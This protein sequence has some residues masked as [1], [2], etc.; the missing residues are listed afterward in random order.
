MEDSPA[1]EC[2]SRPPVSHLLET[3]LYVSDL[4]TSKAFYERIFGF[5]QVFENDR[6]CALEVPGSA[7]LLLFVHNGAM[8]PAGMP[9]VAIPAHGGQGSLHVC[10]AIPVAS[11]DAW[12]A[13][14][15]AEFISVES[16]VTWKYGGTSVYFRDPDGHS[17]EIATPG[18]WAN[19]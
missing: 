11:L 5:T 13:H 7:V 16:K 8:Q 10:F 18:L 9:G 12:I 15:A 3:S 14:L 1:A 17:V 19:Y 2:K 4:G 6:M